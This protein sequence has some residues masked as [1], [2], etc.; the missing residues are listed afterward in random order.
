[1]PDNRA[2]HPASSSPNFAAALQGGV[3]CPEKPDEARR[4]VT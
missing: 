1:M 4:D 3:M 2:E